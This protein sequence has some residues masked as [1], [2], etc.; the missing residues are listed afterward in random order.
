[1]PNK[2]KTHYENLQ[3]I[4]LLCFNKEK[5][6]RKISDANYDVIKEH[7]INGFDSSDERL[8]KV[9]CCTC[10]LTLNEFVKGNFERK[11]K[12]YDHSL[13]GEHGPQTR[14]KFKNTEC[15]C[16]VCKIARETLNKT[17]ITKAAK[18]RPNSDDS[19]S[20][21]N[22]KPTVLKLC[23]QC[24]TTIAQGQAHNCTE[25]TR[26]SN[27]QQI[28]L[29][30]MSSP[31][32]CEKV[33]SGIIKSTGYDENI[34]LAVEGGGKPL[35]LQHFNSTKSPVAS[36]SITSQDMSLIQQDLNLSGR[37]T[38][39]L[40][41][42]LRTALQSRNSVEP[43]LKKGLQRI[44]HQLDSFFEA[45]E[46]EFLIK[47]NNVIT[48]RVTRWTVMCNNINGLIARIKEDREYCEMEDIL[49]KF[50]IDGGGGFMKVCLSLF[51]LPTICGEKEK[52]NVKLYES[53]SIRKRKFK[54]TSVKRLFIIGIIPEIQENYE[55]ILKIWATLK[56][57]ECSSNFTIATD[58]KLTNILIGIM[59]HGSTHPCSWCEAPSNDLANIG[60]HRTIENL[61]H[62]FWDWYGKP[63]SKAKEHMNV[64]HPCLL[65]NKK[66]HTSSNS[67]LEIIPPPELHLLLGPFNTM[68]KGLNSVWED[69][70][71]WLK[72]CSV[73]REA[74]HGGSFNGNSCM[75][76][77]NNVDLLASM[78]PMEALKY[79][80]A[81]RSFHK[82][83]LIF[84]YL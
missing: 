63:R 10:R 65:T 39:K 75:K 41:Q 59:A 76:L 26:I 83:T 44:D 5:D 19:K 40:G 55:N 46:M 42:H 53:G 29:S 8:P 1:M 20:S 12:L 80:A 77:L 78:C 32:A 69:S 22:C 43:N 51:P 57:N 6:M 47:Q 71:N 35:K 81:F 49:I 82:V 23:S 30:P 60:P 34:V 14:F 48:G 52:E 45:K 18:G 15:M 73:E 50:G 62:H 4:C 37:E 68:Y 24:L 70:V 67:L 27:M 9:L 36:V 74:L 56:L 13:V 64:I 58:L 33:I 21:S 84:K 72:A 38:L 61:R 54:D 79:V 66:N 17:L 3:A 25:S 31:K 7:V 11:I 2:A 28:L 16:I